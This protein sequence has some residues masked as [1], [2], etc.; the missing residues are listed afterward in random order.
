MKINKQS[1]QILPVGFYEGFYD[2]LSEAI[3]TTIFQ[4]N[5][6]YQTSIEETKTVILAK[7]VL[8]MNHH[9]FRQLSP[10]LFTYTNTSAQRRPLAK[11]IDDSTKTFDGVKK[12]A[13]KILEESVHG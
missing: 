2:T 5:Q 13:K 9:E 12:W 11:S 4:K 8:L 6:F 10:Y 7:S 1:N 3:L